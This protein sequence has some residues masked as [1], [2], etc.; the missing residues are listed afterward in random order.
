MYIY[1]YIYIEQYKNK[2]S[3]A[4]LLNNPMCHIDILRVEGNVV[5]KYSRKPED[6]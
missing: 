2:L 6:S 5:P 3:M 1:I 4:D